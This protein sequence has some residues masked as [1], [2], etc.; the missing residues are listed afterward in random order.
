MQV[1][2]TLKGAD[3]QLLGEYFFSDIE[4]NPDFKPGTFT[5]DAVAH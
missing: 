2:S 1:G 5:R 4:L 3:G